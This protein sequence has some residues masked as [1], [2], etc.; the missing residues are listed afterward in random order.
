MPGRP[1]NRYRPARSL[2]AAPQKQRKS[3]RHPQSTLST[4]ANTTEHQSVSDK[5]RLSKNNRI[6]TRYQANLHNSGAAKTTPGEAR[7]AGDRGVD[8]RLDIVIA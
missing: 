4:A 7:P 6:G 3:C 5:M 8:A 2:L 1:A